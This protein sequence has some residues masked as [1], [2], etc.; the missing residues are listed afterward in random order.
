MTNFTGG[1][2]MTTITLVTGTVV[3]YN[4]VPGAFRTYVNAANSRGAVCLDVYTD[5]AYTSKITIVLT[6]VVS[7]H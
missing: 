7:F 2:I 6:N 5:Q 3:Y 1:K 4:D